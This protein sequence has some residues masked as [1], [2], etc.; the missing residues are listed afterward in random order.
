MINNNNNSSRLGAEAC[1]KAIRK[2]ESMSELPD[3]DYHGERVRMVSTLTTAA[4]P[5]TPY[6][7]GFITALA[8]YIDLNLGSYPRVTSNWRPEAMMTTEEIETRR[9]ITEALF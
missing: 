5:M 8:E 3:P 7:A 4:G 2:M 6:L 9:A 1:L